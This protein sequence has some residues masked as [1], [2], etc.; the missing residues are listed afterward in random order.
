MTTNS[1]RIRPVV[2]GA[3]L[4]A[5]AS[6]WVAAV[7]AQGTAPRTPA[8][9]SQ[10]LPS[11]DQIRKAVASLRGNRIATPNN[12]DTMT[13]EQQAYV[14]SILTGPRSAISGPLG[15][16]MVTPTLG[17]LTQKAMAYSRFAGDPG[18]SSVP[19]K[20]NELAILIVAR[21]WS[22]EYVWN[23]HHNYAVRVGL[24]REQVEAIRTGRRPE[25]MD[26]DVKAVYDFASQFITNRQV[27]DTTL[28]A[29]KSVLGGD[30]GVVDLV[31]TM[32]LYQISSMMVAMD[33]TPLAPGTKPFFAR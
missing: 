6:V 21:H 8:P 11:L 9:Q 24:T 26:D 3:L 32:G 25:K 31:G 22:A 15:V 1:P 12:Y 5:A 13:P 4:S 16:M 7:S 20:L 2:A 18:F 17:D 27:G 30:R 19:P 10:E 28:Q 14:R 23:A 33:Q 29:A